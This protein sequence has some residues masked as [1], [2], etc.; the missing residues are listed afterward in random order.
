MRLWLHA[1]GTVAK[2]HISGF[3]DRSGRLALPRRATG[4]A[5]LCCDPSSGGI[6]GSHGSGHYRSREL[7]TLLWTQQR[8]SHTPEHDSQGVQRKALCEVLFA[9][10]CGM[11]LKSHVL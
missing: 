10:L 9:V 4:R 8:R 6:P 1:S 3:R 11:L 7:P 2:T 5:G